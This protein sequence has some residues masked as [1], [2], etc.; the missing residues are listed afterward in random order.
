MIEWKK[1]ILLTSYGLKVTKQEDY[2]YKFKIQ[3]P[4]PHHYTSRR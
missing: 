2:D 3:T 1:N 4:S